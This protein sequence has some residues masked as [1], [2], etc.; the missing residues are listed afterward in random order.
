MICSYM[1]LKA[2]FTGKEL[3]TVFTSVTGL[4]FRFFL[5]K[6]YRFFDW[7]VTPI[8]TL[9]CMN[10]LFMKLEHLFMGK[11]ILTQLTLMCFF[12]WCWCMNMSVVFQVSTVTELLIAY[13][14]NML[15]FGLFHF[16]HVNFLMISKKSC[17]KKRFITDI[18]SFILVFYRWNFYHNIRLRVDHHMFFQVVFSCKGGSTIF[19]VAWSFVWR[20][21][22]IHSN[23]M[24]WR[25]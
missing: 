6:F 23:L 18:T 12:Q 21:L 22:D 20:F 8:F 7:E 5:M 10:S 19:T 4:L 2:S 16:F 25:L 9:N 24:F 13:A 14:T 15:L 17:S 11:H 1:S 3:A